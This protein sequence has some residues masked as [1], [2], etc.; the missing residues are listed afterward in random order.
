MTEQRWLIVT[1]NL[2]GGLD[3]AIQYESVPASLRTKEMRFNVVEVWSL[4]G[5]IETLDQAKEAWHQRRDNE[6]WKKEFQIKG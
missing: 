4:P 3:F 1:R 2:K 5:G 6:A